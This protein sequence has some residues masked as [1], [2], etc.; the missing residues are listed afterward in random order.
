M[1]T[2]H[3]PDS[4]QAEWPDAPL[5]DAII[6]E[7]L[8]VARAEVIAYAPVLADPSAVPATY[9]VAQLMQ[10]RAIWNSQ[11][12]NPAGE[13]GGEG[14]AIRFYPLDGHIRQLLR[15]RRAVPKVA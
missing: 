9:R 5:D 8:D 4:A 3:D 14:F 12:A 6:A 11:N 13:L 2:W 1:A 7:L 10:A 15:P